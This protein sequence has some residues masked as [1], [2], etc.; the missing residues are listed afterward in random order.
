MLILTES[1]KVCKS[2]QIWLDNSPSLAAAKITKE[3][4]EDLKAPK[5]ELFLFENSGYQ[6]HQDEPEKFQNTIIKT[7]DRIK[8]EK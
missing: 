3:Y 2:V 5:K 7:L 1:V 8:S 4:F 6:I